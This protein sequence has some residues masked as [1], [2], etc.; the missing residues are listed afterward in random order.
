MCDVKLMCWAEPS[1]IY[2]P[3]RKRIGSRQSKDLMDSSV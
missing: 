3:G 2:M 1:P